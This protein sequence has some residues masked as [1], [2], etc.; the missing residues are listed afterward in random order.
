MLKSVPCVD[1]HQQGCAGRPPRRI[2]PGPG[3]SLFPKTCPDHRRFEAS[4][5]V[6]KTGFQRLSG[7]RKPGTT[8][9]YRASSLGLI[10][11]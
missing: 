10:V 11:R 1:Y 6:L 5:S 8:E 3:A 9:G 7:I 4:A 2:G